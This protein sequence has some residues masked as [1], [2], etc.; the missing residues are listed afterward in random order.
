MVAVHPL[1][2]ARRRAA[3]V[4]RILANPFHQRPL[5]R[6]SELR[7]DLPDGHALSFVE[8]GHA[9][10]DV[11]AQ[12]EFDHE[13]VGFAVFGVGRPIS[14]IIGF[15]LRCCSSSSG[16]LALRDYVVCD[17]LTF[18]MRDASNVILLSMQA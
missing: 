8:V 2:H 6:V 16:V 10:P 17:D 13:V 11:V 12:D 7:N 9:L 5:G 1:V 18:T 15:V 14:A 4:A 3:R